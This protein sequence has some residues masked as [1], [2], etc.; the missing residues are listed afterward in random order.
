M[1]LG[2][3]LVGQASKRGLIPRLPS[4]GQLIETAERW[5]RATFPEVVRSSHRTDDT[6]AG[7]ELRV[8]LHPAAPDVV[9]TADA[10]GRVTAR[11]V[12][13]PAGPGFHT[14]ACGLLHQ[15]GSELD[16]GW[17]PL[18][19]SG[20]SVDPTGFFASTDRRDAERV[21]LGWLG[22]TLA[23]AVEDRRRGS[24]TIHL[25]TPD[26]VRYQ[27]D[28]ALATPLGPRDDAW[29]ARAAGDPRV[30]VDLWP[31][32]AD[33]MDGRYLMLRALCLMWTA[34]RWRR[35]SD[36][37]ERAEI[38][39]ALRLLRRAYQLDP[40][41]SYPWRE[42]LELLELAG[43]SGAMAGPI[44]ERAAAVDPA[45]PLIGYRRQQ[46]TIYQA[47]WELTIPGSFAERRTAD[48]WWGSESGRRIALAATRAGTSAGPMSAEA[49]LDQVAGHLGSSALHHQAG[50]VNGRARIAT[51]DSSGVSTGI[52]EGYVAVPGSGAVIRVEFDDPGDWQWAL[53][54]WRSLRP[55]GARRSLAL[56][57]A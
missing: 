39:E 23:R 25:G 11:A 26:G 30:A 57:G 44:A 15:L 31:W 41:L 2:F 10:A 50:E 35:P 16:I 32:F 20:G 48:G 29:L 24:S 4:G 37:A 54:Q 7:S 45:T 33:V 51:D 46:V 5:I 18:G 53:D 36:A 13:S 3:H 52:V 12:T 17:A 19:A 14:F 21:A 1:D 56:A 40:S 49:L 6:T 47:G 43:S 34:V 55:A 8:G 28:G 38:D 22:A 42:W 27:V 9:L